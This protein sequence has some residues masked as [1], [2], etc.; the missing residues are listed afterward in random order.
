MSDPVPTTTKLA[1]AA[2]P[3]V[4]AVVAEDQPGRD[5]ADTLTAIGSRISLRQWRALRDAL[6]AT[7]AATHA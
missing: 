6:A 7:E 4:A 3:L 1:E 5:V 2:R